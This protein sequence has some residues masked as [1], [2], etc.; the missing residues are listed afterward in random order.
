MYSLIILLIS[1][2]R[3]SCKFCKQERT[4]ESHNKYKNLSNLQRIGNYILQLHANLGM[5]SS[6]CHI[7]DSL[8]YF[9]PNQV[10]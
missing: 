6:C 1:S 2:L 10:K 3:Y 9:S 4:V 8:A 7:F 5:C